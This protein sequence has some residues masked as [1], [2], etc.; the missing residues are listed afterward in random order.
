MSSLY[1]DKACEKQS[2][3]PLALGSFDGVHLGHSALLEKAVEIAKTARSKSSVLTFSPNPKEFFSTPQKPYSQIYSFEQ[4]VEEIKNAGVDEVFIKK[5]DED[6]SKMT[7]DE[8][9]NFVFF[10]VKF[11]D[12]VVGFDFKFGKDR[13]GNH[14]NLKKWCDK[15]EV[16]LHIVKAQKD[17]VGKISS[18]RIKKKLLKGDIEKASK[19][20]GRPHRYL[21]RICSDQGL[22]KKIGF[23]TL[24]I[25]LDLSTAIAYGVYASLIKSGKRHYRGISNIGLRPTVFKSAANL[26]LETHVLGSNNVLIKAGDLVEIEL[27]N[28]IRSE[29][30]F[31]NIEQLKLQISQDIATAKSLA[32]F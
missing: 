3:G 12:L 31:A 32:R 17:S 22:G 29:K 6:C 7:A 2:V 13:S 26:V 16:K 30:K 20:L 10:K 18:T 19:L 28:F 4:N 23:P 24:N 15:N 1:L 21:G 9:L 25:K 8:F 11:S 14:Q 5:F 27:H